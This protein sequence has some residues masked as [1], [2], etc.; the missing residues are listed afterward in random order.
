MNGPSNVCHDLLARK[1]PMTI[2]CPRPQTMTGIWGTFRVYSPGFPVVVMMSIGTFCDVHTRQP[3]MGTRRTI[4]LEMKCPAGYQLTGMFGS[5]SDFVNEIGIEC[6]RVSDGAAYKSKLFAPVGTKRE[7]SVARD[8]E[9]NA[10]A[11]KLQFWTGPVAIDGLG[12]CCR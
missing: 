12:F 7:K 2:D 1:L 3:E 5:F 8:C 6:K 9:L 10:A 4:P 11:N